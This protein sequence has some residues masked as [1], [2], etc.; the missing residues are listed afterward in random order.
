MKYDN[1]VRLFVMFPG[2]RPRAQQDL[3]RR[4]K[5]SLRPPSSVMSPDHMWLLSSW[6]VGSVSKGLDFSCLLF[7][8]I[9]IEIQLQIATFN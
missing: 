5:C 9:D 3:L 1:A 7:Q 8:L 2:L 4:G 6:Y